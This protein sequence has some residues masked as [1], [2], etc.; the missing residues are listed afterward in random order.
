MN[1]DEILLSRALP[2]ID[3]RHIVDINYYYS[4]SLDIFARDSIKCNK[5]LRCATPNGHI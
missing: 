5:V 4:F 3:I 2:P 1:E